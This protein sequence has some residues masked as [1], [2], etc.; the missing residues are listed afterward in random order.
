MEK[1]H[2]PGWTVLPLVYG[3][4]IAVEETQELF[5]FKHALELVVRINPLFR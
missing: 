3:L 5:S 2:F 1:I 4:Q